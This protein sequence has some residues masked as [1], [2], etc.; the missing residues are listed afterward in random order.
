MEIMTQNL[1]HCE[2]EHQ[3]EDTLFLTLS[4][5]YDKSIGKNIMYYITLS[6]QKLIELVVKIF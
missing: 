3:K 6:Q 1:I 4:H 5:Q 2:K